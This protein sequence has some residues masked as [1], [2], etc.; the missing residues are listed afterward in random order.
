[1]VYLSKVGRKAGIPVMYCVCSIFLTLAVVIVFCSILFIY[2]MTKK[3][4]KKKKKLFL[5]IL[6][7]DWKNQVIRDT[8]RVVT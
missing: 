7:L 2:E 3:K 5:Q 4:T 6:S 8:Q 1:M